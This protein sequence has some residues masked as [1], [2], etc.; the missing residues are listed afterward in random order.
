MV[1]ICMQGPITITYHHPSEAAEGTRPY[2]EVHV[3]PIEVT[4]SG[5]ATGETAL[6]Y[7]MRHFA[8]AI[9]VGLGEAAA[10]AQK[11]RS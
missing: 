6:A 7:A 9:R 1:T 5:A 8:E 3:P 4:V 10:A 2:T 11:T